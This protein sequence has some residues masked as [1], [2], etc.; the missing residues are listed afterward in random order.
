MATP[1][2]H[3]TSGGVEY[4]V[5]LED[6]QKSASDTHMTAHDVAELLLQL[7]TYVIGLEDEWQGMAAN[8]FQDLMVQWRK[9]ADQLNEALIAIGDGL[10]GNY[11][12]YGENEATNQRNMASIKGNLPTANFA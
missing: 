2:P 5:T 1:A 12:N 11:H 10:M 3:T 8:E 6:L 4:H 9:Y 7:Q